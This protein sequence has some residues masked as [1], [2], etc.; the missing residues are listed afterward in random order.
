MNTTLELSQDQAKFIKEAVKEWKAINKGREFAGWMKIGAALMIGRQL[1]FAR[2]RTNRPEGKAYN[3]AFSRWCRE[4][5]FTN[6]EIDPPTRS[7]LLFLQEP[8]HRVICDEIRAAMAQSERLKVNHPRGMVRRV[9]AYLRQR[10]GEPPKRR[11]TGDERVRE[12]EH[13]L[14]DAQEQLAGRDQEHFLRRIEPMSLARRIAEE[15]QGDR[16]RL[17]ELVDDLNAVIDELDP[18]LQAALKE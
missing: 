2:L 8:E 6:P 18:D 3:E 14:A 15:W 5:G 4:H 9:R 1:I 13:E 16:D 7:D 17:I 11:A 12:L 10:E